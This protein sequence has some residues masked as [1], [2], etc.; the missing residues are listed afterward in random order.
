[1]QFLTANLQSS[2]PRSLP[3][4]INNFLLLSPDW[5]RRR[6]PEKKLY[7]KVGRER[8]R[9]R[10][11][12]KGKRA[13]KRVLQNWKK[14]CSSAPPP[15]PTTPI[16]LLLS[17]S[18]SP[19]VHSGKQHETEWNQPSLLPFLLPP[20]M[21]PWDIDWKKAQLISARVNSTA[22]PATVVCKIEV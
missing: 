11:R 17:S 19:P 13:K 4:F 10:E 16:K 3:L 14:T 8:E 21:F 12:V 9:E 5:K 7:A 2:Y 15:H 6:I 18:S 20:A 22:Q 1:M